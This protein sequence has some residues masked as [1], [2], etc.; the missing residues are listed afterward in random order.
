MIY[1][2]SIFYVIGNSGN[3][4]AKSIQFVH[5]K[6]NLKI[7]DIIYVTAKNIINSLKV[8]KKTIYLGL[9]TNSKY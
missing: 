5:K 9:I 4:L 2:N 1:L 6:N 8:N 7:T 3:K